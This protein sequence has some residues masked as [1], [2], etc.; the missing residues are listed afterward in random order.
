MSKAPYP[1]PHQI[2]E[3]MEL[4]ENPETRDQFK[5]YLSK[6]LDAKIMGVDHQVAGEHKGGEAFFQYMMEEMGTM[7]D[8]T[9][10]Q[11]YDTINVIGGGESSW[12][13]YEGKAVSKTKSGKKWDHDFVYVMRFNLDGKITKIRAYFDTAHV[14]TH[15]EANRKG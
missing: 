9:K 11:K 14:N 15:L 10:P 13:C 5:T 2:E 12:A 4:R 3:I 7:L 8:E 6:N 1:S